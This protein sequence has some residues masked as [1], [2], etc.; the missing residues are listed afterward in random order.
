M[1]EIRSLRESFVRIMSEYVHAR[2]H[3][4]YGGHELGTLIRQQLPRLILENLS[5]SEDINP[6]NYRINGSIGQGNWAYV[7]WLVIMDRDI[8]VTTQEG[9]YV[10]YLFSE[11]MERVYLA[12]NQ[13]VTKADRRDYLAKKNTL[14][15]S[16][17]FQDFQVDGNIRLSDKPLGR[18][19]EQ[20]TVAYRQYNKTDLVNG[21]TTEEQLINDLHQMML[22][23]QEYKEQIWQPDNSA[24]QNDN[25]EPTSEPVVAEVISH[26]KEYITAKGFAYPDG[27]IENFYL[28]L[29]TKPFVLLAGIS[30]TG[31]T[32]LV[33]L[34]AEAIGCRYKLISVRPDWNDGSD[35]LG[36][37]NI[38]GKFVAGPI[39]DFIKA[40]NDDADNIYLVCLDEMNLARVEYYFSDFLSIM[41]TRK[42]VNKNIVTDTIIDS[43]YFE[44]KSDQAYADLILPDNLYIVGTVNM[45]ETTHPFSKKV[46]DRANTIEFSEI[47]LD[48]FTLLDE[49]NSGLDT[50]KVNPAFLKS[51]YVT[52]RDC[53]IENE[54]RL[55]DI[56][57]RLMEINDILKEANLQIGY[58]IR[59]EICFYM[60]YNNQ[61]ELLTENAAF[62]FQLMQKVLPRIQGSSETIKRVL[63]KLFYFTAGRDYSNEDGTIGSKAIN[64]VNANN[65]L[66]FPRSS[67]KIAFMIKRFE[68]DG[69]TS[70]WL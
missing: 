34:F 32:K 55:G 8:T 54:D 14:R 36:Y 30:G 33:Q 17:N 45:D 13:G 27:L 69:F 6:N 59:D 15:D 23:Y 63:I 62:D 9:E 57:G 39:I 3:E 18:K 49:T 2:D 28:S 64:F 70:F 10:A 66:P 50:W 37:K 56:I 1:V 60:L 16:I 53:G 58:R 5:A 22:I 42:K 25:L 19:Y 52:L 51:K 44:N 38:Q 11:D 21:I 40:A 47:H 29:K 67:A 20:S 26:I 4:R 48:M 12:F 41:E 35:L 46:L 7:P 65:D 61:E 68:E 24:N 31:K 43:N